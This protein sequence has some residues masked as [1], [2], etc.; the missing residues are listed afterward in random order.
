M[1]TNLYGPGDN[2]HRENSHVIAAI[3]RKMHEAKIEDINEVTLW[4]SGSP[5]REFM[6]V[7]DLSKFIVNIMFDNSEIFNEILSYETPIVNVGSAQE[8]KI[9]ELANI[10]SKV[11]G[12]KGSIK[13]DISMPDGTPRKLLDTSKLKK[14][15]NFKFIS[16]EEGLQNTYQDFLKKYN[17]IEN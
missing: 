15:C 10:I 5:R 1:P 17:T 8:L 14:F 7:D 3:I 9:S 2:Y 4:G 11:I 16:L 12:F 6:H 13:Y